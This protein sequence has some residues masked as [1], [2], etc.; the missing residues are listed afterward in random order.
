M[1]LV[2]LCSAKGGTG[3]TTLAFNLAER[4]A[5]AGLRVLVLD[6]DPQE[7]SVGLSSLRSGAGVDP[8]RLWPVER[9]HVGSGSVELLSELRRKQ[10]ADLVV[11]D[12][13]GNENN[14][15]GQVLSALDLVLSPVCGTA[16]DLMS[17]V[18]FHM[19]AQRMDVPVRFVANNM[20]RG[21]KR[22]SFL[23]QELEGRQAKVCPVVVHRRVAYQDSQI[24]G[25]GVAE[26]GPESPAAVEMT[27]L[28]EWLLQELYLTDLFA[29]RVS[30]AAS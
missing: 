5:A 22:V 14:A 6:F 25:L 11:C 10:A 4:A 30:Y 12:L 24:Q 23:R 16:L 7:A 27:S 29:G 13:P 15:L 21:N 28:W 2:G 1:W 26:A 19:L 3:K 17:A 8:G 20:N 9:M 18:D